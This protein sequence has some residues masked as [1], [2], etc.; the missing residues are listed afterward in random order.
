[1]FLCML[2]YYASSTSSVTSSSS[3]QTVLP[4]TSNMDVP[5]QTS[6]RDDQDEVLGPM[7]EDNLPPVSNL[8]AATVRK[9]DDDDDDDDNKQ[10]S[11]SPVTMEDNDKKHSTT[12]VS[13]PSTDTN[14]AL[15]AGTMPMTISKNIDIPMKNEPNISLSVMETSS[16]GTVKQKVSSIFQVLI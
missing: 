4:S 8:E 11:D 13:S 9:M 3:S 1:M 14:S 16:L 2:G 7:D 12:D 6:T 15:S 5:D 10:N